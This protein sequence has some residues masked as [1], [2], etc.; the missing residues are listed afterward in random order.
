MEKIT[1]ELG[2]DSLKEFFKMA[3]NVD[4]TSPDK[5]KAFE[6][7]KQNDGSKKGLLKLKTKT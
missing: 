6:K 2:F 4:L 3:A 1:K 5:I 7:W